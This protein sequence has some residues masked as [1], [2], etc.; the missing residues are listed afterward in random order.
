VCVGGG[1]EKEARG[2]D[3]S[4]DKRYVVV[5]GV[6]G[7]AITTERGR[8]NNERGMVPLDSPS[9]LLIAFFLI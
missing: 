8:R 9:A 4:F 7:W 3:I 1:G 5:C 2:V 6:L